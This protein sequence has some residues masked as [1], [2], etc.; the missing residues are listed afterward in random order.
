MT[1]KVRL[2]ERVIELEAVNTIMDELKT[3]A[4]EVRE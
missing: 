2:Q 3:T 4:E 1:E